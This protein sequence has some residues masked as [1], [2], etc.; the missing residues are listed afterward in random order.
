M[1][2]FSILLIFCVLP[3]QS[4]IGK[5]LTGR[6]G[7]GFTSRQMSTTSPAL[8]MRFG[9][10]DNLSAEAA[11]GIESGGDSDSLVIGGRLF[12]HAYQQ[13]NINFLLGLSVFLLREEV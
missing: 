13:D 10:S 2:K 12:R 3:F 8:S 1:K 5:D 7:L 9:L 4:A 11:L 6:I